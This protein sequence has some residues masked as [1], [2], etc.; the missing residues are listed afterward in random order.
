MLE[1]YLAMKDCLKSRKDLVLL[2]SVYKN[3]NIDG[4][5]IIGHK[6]VPIAY[7][8]VIVA[9]PKNYMKSYSE[10]LELS[11]DVIKNV[12]NSFANSNKRI[13]SSLPQVDF[14]YSKT[15][16]LWN[17]TAAVDDATPLND[18][19]DVINCETILQKPFNAR[20]DQDRGAFPVNLKDNEE[21]IGTQLYVIRTRL[22]LLPDRN[23]R[24][25]SSDDAHGEPLATIRETNPIFRYGLIDK[26]RNHGVSL[27]SMFG[28]R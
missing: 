23:Y 3:E 19:L 20:L 25:K 10:Y 24:P 8:N 18:I 27:K 1:N 2:D 13:W 11:K 12:K 22:C 14:S 15:G 9:A 21:N 5:G 17:A 6:F 16:F 28:P 26:I 7:E 4:F